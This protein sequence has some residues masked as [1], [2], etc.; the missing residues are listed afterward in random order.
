VSD[1]SEGGP[2][3]GPIDG[4]AGLDRDP[5]DATTVAHPAVDDERLF[6][7]VAALYGMAF[8]SLWLFG[9][10]L[11]ATAVAIQGG[12][13]SVLA[14]E[15]WVAGPPGLVALLAISPLLPLGLAVLRERWRDP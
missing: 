3:E 2:L 4:A 8:G 6:R 12:W 9:V 7:T 5:R 14:V 10:W 15:P 1:E 13:R 11:A